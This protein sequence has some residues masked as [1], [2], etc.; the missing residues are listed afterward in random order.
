MPLMGLR[1][2][3]RY[4]GCS[5]TAV[6][7]AIR[8]GRIIAVKTK[9]RGRKKPLVQIDSAAADVAWT[10]NTDQERSARTAS[11]HVARTSSKPSDAATDDAA[12]EGPVESDYDNTAPTPNALT[13]AKTDGERERA[14]MVELK[15]KILEREYLPKQVVGA[16]WS[17]ISTQI[18][19]GMLNLPARIGSRIAA[20]YQTALSAMVQAIDEGRTVT[21]QDLANVLEAA[22]DP[23]HVNDI[24]EQEIKAVLSVLANGTIDLN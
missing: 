3:S 21:K 8:T 11:F 1:E 16:T 9:I 24:M 2:Y 20:D 7:T 14:R 6:E 22:G 10:A 4:R 19:N 23:K 18:Q 13:A 17:K 15:R 12:S 5:K